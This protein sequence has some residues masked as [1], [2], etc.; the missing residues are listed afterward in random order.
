MINYV[1]IIWTNFHH[2]QIYDIIK[3]NERKHGVQIS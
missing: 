2:K 1:S 3:N